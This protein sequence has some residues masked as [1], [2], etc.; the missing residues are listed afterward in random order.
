MTQW[1][2]QS[3]QNRI[4]GMI[5]SKPDWVISRQRAWGVPI[6]VFVKKGGHE[7]LIDERVNA[8][9]AAAFARLE[10]SS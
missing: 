3:G 4:N 7:I 5:N 9:I 1:V 8:R 2:P 6:A 10:P